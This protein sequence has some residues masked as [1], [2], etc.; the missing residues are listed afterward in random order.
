MNWGGKMKIKYLILGAGISGLSFASKLKDT[1]YIIIE[2]E[3]TAGGL[4]RTHKVNGYTWDFAGHFFHFKNEDTKA[5]FAPVLGN[6]QCIKQTKNTKIYIKEKYVDYPFQKNIHQL[7]KDD[8]IDCLYYLYFKKEKTD[9]DSFKD[10]LLGKF[11]EGICNR[12]LIPYNEKLYACDL[13]KLDKDAMGRFF[14][15]ADFKDII[16]NMKKKASSNSYNDTFEYPINGAQSVID[17][18][19]KLIIKDNLLLEEEILAVD[20]NNKIVTTDKGQYEYQYLI[21]TIPFNQFINLCKIKLKNKLSW[22]KVLV[23]NIGFDLPALDKNIHWVYYPSKEINFYRVGFYNN[24]LLQNKL[25]IY[26]EIGYSQDQVIEINEEFINTLE[27]LRKCGIIDKHKVVSY[28]SIIID[29][30]YVHIAQKNIEEI[31]NTMIRLNKQNIYTLGRYGAWTYCSMEDCY[32]SAIDLAKK[33]QKKE[34]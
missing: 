3:A 5:F 19:E 16:C 10:M 22:N 8:F 1:N 7:D 31:N 17:F 2:K 9:Y 27:N 21:N 13:N 34:V 28:E 18:L 14:P 30:G 32:M 6:E 4:C 26:V 15:Y 25:S 23:F 20:P 29:P 33:L 11:G 24:I 12:F